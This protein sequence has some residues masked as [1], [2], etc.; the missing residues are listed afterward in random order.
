M[1]AEVMLMAQVKPQ[2][3]WVAPHPDWVL[4]VVRTSVP[5]LPAC[6]TVQTIEIALIARVPLRP[7]SRAG[8]RT[9]PNGIGPGV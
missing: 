7:A 8:A 5:L 3:V 9:D 1:T 6:M 2:V 4:A